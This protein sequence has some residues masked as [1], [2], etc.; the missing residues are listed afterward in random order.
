MK[1]CKICNVD[2]KTDKNYCPLCFNQMQ[3]KSTE[4]PLYLCNTDKR[5]QLKKHYLANKILLFI[6]LVAVCICGFINFITYSGVAWSLVVLTGLV[7]LWILIRHAIMSN[8][9]AFEKVFFQFVGVLAITISSYFIS[10]GGD[11]LLNYVVPSIAI[12]TSVILVMITLCNKRRKNF[13]MGF[14][15]I[16]F[17]LLTLSIVLLA[18]KFDTFKVLNEINLLVTSLAILGT[19]FFGFKTIKNELSKKLHL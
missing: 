13:L 4:K 6:S 15:V 16:Y 10:S 12:T 2:V 17:L 19:L 8:R 18:C 1:H 11:W 7:Y 5:S 14:L 9:S 3:G